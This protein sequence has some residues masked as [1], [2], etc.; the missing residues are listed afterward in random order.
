M[1]TET[2]L[3]RVQPCAVCQSVSA[4]GR[5]RL[6]DAGSELLMRLLYERRGVALKARRALRLAGAKAN[7]YDEELEDINRL[8]HEIK[9]TQHEM[10]WIDGEP[11]RS[12][13]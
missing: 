4:G 12:H 2:R 9:R 13:A 8:Y 10:G 3:D 7:D 5:I 11:Q 6:T 1:A